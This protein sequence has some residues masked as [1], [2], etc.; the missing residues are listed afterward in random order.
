MHQKDQVLNLFWPKTLM[1]HLVKNIEDMTFKK[2]NPA[3]YQMNPRAAMGYH[4]TLVIQ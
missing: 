1:T 3:L 2:I 4:Q